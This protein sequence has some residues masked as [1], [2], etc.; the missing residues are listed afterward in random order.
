[1]N[2][3]GRN[4]AIGSPASGLGQRSGLSALDEI[5]AY[6]RTV[7]VDVAAALKSVLLQEHGYLASNDRPDWRTSSVR[8]HL[9]FAG[10]KQCVFPSGP[11]RRTKL[12]QAT[13]WHSFRLKDLT[14]PT[15]G[16][17]SRWPKGS[18]E[19][20]TRK[21]P[22]FASETSMSCPGGCLDFRPVRLDCRL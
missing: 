2:S 16:N 21:G 12:R 17:R 6:A 15:P 13:D 11:D 18:I 19:R 14:G 5:D 3:I 1:M 7:G 10:Q 4:C 22:F 20:R 8:V 9:P